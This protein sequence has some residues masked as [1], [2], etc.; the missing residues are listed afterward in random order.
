MCKLVDG[1]CLLRPR[2]SRRSRLRTLLASSRTRRN[3]LWSYSGRS[4]RR[5]G[6]ASVV[7]SM[8][9]QRGSVPLLNAAA[10][11]CGVHVLLGVVVLSGSELPFGV[12]VGALAVV[13]SSLSVGSV[14]YCG[15]GGG[16]GAPTLRRSCSMMP[17][18]GRGRRH[19]L[20]EW[21]LSK[22]WLWHR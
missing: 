8:W 2:G 3:S 21:R 18:P 1:M 10:I 20:H 22:L 14:M 6:L 11:C 7:V 19:L 5:S 15:S 16:G 12:P 13:S 17:V 9:D 4:S